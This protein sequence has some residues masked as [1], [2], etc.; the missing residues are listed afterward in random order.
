LISNL[1]RWF[2]VGWLRAHRPLAAA[3]HGCSPKLRQPAAPVPYSRWGLDQN[4]VERMRVSPSVLLGGGV[5]GGGRAMTA[6]LLQALVMVK[7]SCRCL[8]S[9][10]SDDDE[11]N[12]HGKNSS[13]ARVW[14][15]GQKF[16]QHRLL[17]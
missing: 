7:S 10:A 16:G 17:F 8:S 12:L 2:E 5:T 1:D 6:S 4:K 14:C 15:G 11:S 9:I 13:V 3:A